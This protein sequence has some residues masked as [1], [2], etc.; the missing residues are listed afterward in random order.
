M[1]CCVNHQLIQSLLASALFTKKS[2]KCSVIKQY[3]ILFSRFPLAHTH[4]DISSMFKMNQTLTRGSISHFERGMKGHLCLK[5]A[6][7]GEKEGCIRFIGKGQSVTLEITFR[8][9]RVM[10]KVAQQH[11]HVGFMGKCFVFS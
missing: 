4:G 9:G 6:E 10:R 7:A 8:H 2:P 1:C 3:K 11:S 5:D